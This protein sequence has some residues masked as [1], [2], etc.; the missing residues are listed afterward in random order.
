VAS[1]LNGLCAS[2]GLLAGFVVTVV[3][4]VDRDVDSG[5]GFVDTVDSGV[6]SDDDEMLVDVVVELMTGANTEQEDRT[7][8]VTAVR[9]VTSIWWM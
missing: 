5:D 7:V 3:S 6:D 9:G 1:F 2:V 4:G 8:D